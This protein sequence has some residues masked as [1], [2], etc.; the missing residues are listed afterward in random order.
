[1]ELEKTVWS[2]KKVEDTDLSNKNFE[3]ILNFYDKNKFE[4]NMNI[5]SSSF[6]IDLDKFLDNTSN[7]PTTNE[8][9]DDVF[10]SS[11]LS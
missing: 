8:L 2:Y 3:I 1:M 10:T 4:I 5:F 9:S 6:N 11:K 7:S